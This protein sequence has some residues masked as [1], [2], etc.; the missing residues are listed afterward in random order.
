MK[1]LY[2][3]IIALAEMTGASPQGWKWLN[4]V[5]QGNKLNCVRFVDLNTGFGVGDYGAIIK[6]S[7]GGESWFLQDT[8]TLEN[9]NSIYLIDPNNGVAVGTNGT[10]LKTCS[11]GTTWNI[12]TSITSG[13]LSGVFFTSLNTGYIIGYNTFEALGFILKTI[14]G[15]NTWSELYIIEL[16]PGEYIKLRSI[17]FTTDIIGFVVG[18]K[19]VNNYVWAYL[20]STNDGGLTWEEN[21]YEFHQLNSVFFPSENIGYAVGSYSGSGWVIKTTNSGTAWLEVDFAPENIYFISQHFTDENIGYL[22]GNDDIAVTGSVIFKTTDGGLNWDAQNLLDGTM[23]YSLDF[24]S[25]TTGLAVG[26]YGFIFRTIDGGTSWLIDNSVATGYLSSVFF[27]DVNTGFAGGAKQGYGNGGAILK[28][29]D[30]GG[31]WSVQNFDH[32]ISSICFANTVSGYATGYA[33]DGATIY[34]TTDS[35]NSWSS[36]VFFESVILN[37]IHCPD[38]NNCYAVGAQFD[39][40]ELWNGI[41]YRTGDGGSNWTTVFNDLSGLQ[42]VFFTNPD[43]GYIIGNMSYLYSEIL[44]TTDGGSEWISQIQL[45]YQYLQSIFFIDENN[46][47]AVGHN[48]Y[49]GFF[50]KTTDGGNNWSEQVIPNS[51]IFYSVFFSDENVGYIVGQE[52]IIYKTTDAG[53]IWTM[54]ESPTKNTFQSVFFTDENTGYI[55]GEGGTILKTTTGGTTEIEENNDNT[56]AITVKIFPNP[57]KNKITISSPALTGIVQ[58]SIFNISGEKVMER[59]LTNNETQLDISALP[60]GV[61]FVRVQDEER[62]EVMKL[63]KQ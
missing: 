13:V 5:P 25:Q 20:L 63:I 48:S 61:Y 43:T 36:Q 31:S 8:P 9:L 3:L 27:T 47:F 41:A 59:R 34:K 53:E 39:G 60:R 57:S 62:I 28:T 18:E 35:G 15:G 2:I 24:P 38:E 50:I 42:D 56:F 30:A 33:Y 1:K 49:D 54:Q 37:S 46:G 6:T 4:P 26:D 51:S 29:T 11:G 21:D 19:T 14:D 32:Y 16:N 12:Q 44:K 17:Y 40:V 55:V 22:L 52:G 7:D 23:V 58:L 45:P 10:I